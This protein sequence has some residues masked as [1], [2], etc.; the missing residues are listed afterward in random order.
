MEHI[1]KDVDRFLFIYFS[2]ETNLPIDLVFRGIRDRVGVVLVDERGEHIGK[3][4]GLAA[5]VV[6]RFAFL[7][8]FFIIYY[9]IL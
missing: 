1:G 8:F 7:F 3:D 9:Y 5:C 4:D 2:F 6:R